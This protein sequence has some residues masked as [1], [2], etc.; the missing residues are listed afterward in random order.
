MSAE[1]PDPAP[2][3]I[4]GAKIVKHRFHHGIDW[5]VNISHLVVGVAVIAAVLFLWSRLDEDDEE[6]AG[7]GRVAVD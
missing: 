6:G 3:N 1:M 2:E 5:Q 7:G 4:D